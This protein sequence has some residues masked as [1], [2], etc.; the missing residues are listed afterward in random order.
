M[1]TAWN[2]EQAQLLRRIALAG[3]GC[4]A[5]QC[6]G[7]ALDAFDRDG[8]CPVAVWRPRCPNG[9]RM[10]PRSRATLTQALLKLYRPNQ[11]VGIPVPARRCRL[12][13]CE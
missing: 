5:E 6:Q 13:K 11:L 9:C 4:P 8:V 2:K 10:G 1:H 3:G 12:K 7:P